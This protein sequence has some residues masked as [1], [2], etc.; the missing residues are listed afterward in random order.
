MHMTKISYAGEQGTNPL[1]EAACESLTS[2]GGVQNPHHHLRFFFSLGLGGARKQI[3]SMPSKYNCEFPVLLSHACAPHH[4]KQR[5]PHGVS[6]L[7][8]P[9]EGSDCDI[10]SARCH[11]NDG[12]RHHPA[13]LV[14]N[15]NHL[16]VLPTH[17]GQAAQ[18]L[19]LQQLH[20]HL[21]EEGWNQSPRR[22]PQSDGPEATLVLRL[23]TQIIFSTD[24]Y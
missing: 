17:T 5:F 9:V 14:L 11:G 8:L 12:E 15:M 2:A 6:N 19:M 23:L 13:G 7:L 22:P 20:C 21:V 24:T 4:H 16:P 3:T 18:V 1:P 10:M